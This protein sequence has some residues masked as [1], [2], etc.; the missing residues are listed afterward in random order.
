MFT[1]LFGLGLQ[2]HNDQLFG[3][4][5]WGIRQSKGYKVQRCLV[6]PTLGGG[7]GCILGLVWDQLGWGPLWIPTALEVLGQWEA[8]RRSTVG[9]QG[10]LPHP[11]LPPTAPLLPFGLPGELRAW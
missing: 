1:T 9:A 10:R 8:E 5:V 3:V 4:P 6:A 11:G 7:L 2:W